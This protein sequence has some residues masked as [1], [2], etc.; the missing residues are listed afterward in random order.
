MR[1]IDNKK[2]E[3]FLLVINNS[4]A[5][6]IV[7]CLFAAILT[8]I[9]VIYNQSFVDNG[10]AAIYE[11]TDITEIQPIL[12]NGHS[13]L[14]LIL[15]IAL[16]VFYYHAFFQTEYN[17]TAFKPFAIVISL[18]FSCCMMIGA[19]FRQYNRIIPFHRI[20]LRTQILACVAFLGFA[21][22]YYAITRFIV[23]VIT[24][25]RCILRDESSTYAQNRRQQVVLKNKTRGNLSN[26]GHSFLRHK[27]I[28]YFM[29]LFLCYLPYLIFFYPGTIQYDAM[30]QINGYFGTWTFTNHH[31]T[32]STI[33]IGLFIQLGRFLYNDNLGVFLY[34][35]V[36]MTGMAYVLADGLVLIEK[37]TS[38]RTPVILSLLYFA[39]SPI[40]P[41]YSITIIKDIS[42]SIALFHFVAIIIKLHLSYE[43]FTE[44]KGNMVSFLLT[45]LFVCLFRHEGIFVV[46]VTTVALTIR[47]IKIKST[48][49]ILSSFAACM[50][51][52]FT[53]NSVS[54]NVFG[55]VK[56]SS[57]SWLSI[58]LQQTAR[59]VSVHSDEVSEAERQAI[60]NVLQYD[61]ITEKYYPEISD[62][63]K[64]L[65]KMN[66]S[67][68]PGKWVAYFKVWF[69]QFLKHPITYMEA[70]INNCY[71][72]FYPDRD[73][74]LDGIGYYEIEQRPAVNVGS[75]QATA[76]SVFANKR[77]A[78]QNIANGFKKAPL[79]GMLYNCGVQCWIFIFAFSLFISSSKRKYLI[80]LL[81]AFVVFLV[82]IASPVNAYLRY[83]LPIIM[84]LPFTISW[85]N[86]T[87]QNGN[88][89]KLC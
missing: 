62:G 52:L 77:E 9:S 43:D 59:Y 47:Y 53:F 49:R 2:L 36:Q 29:I 44:K 71:G 30:A 57:A 12:V 35:L 58:P 42:Y 84:T 5:V 24:N 87:F 64:N 69:G 45:S 80:P 13:F 54:T 81:P 46:L 8:C 61:M 14:F 74:F 76:L 85:T 19:S 31:P 4:K 26:P 7:A 38:K 60:D 55:V 48:K 72:Y 51:L 32:F 10:I 27:I 34:T 86:Y 20:A 65:V 88:L 82:C 83:I 68:D 23:A 15:A 21:I 78:I 56:F 66:I 37:I 39:L 41:I 17:G 25:N 70:T 6:H 28:I 67:S 40:F 89:S 16:V 22:L 79:V 3:A 75:I 11:F 63:A 1:K 73:I 18:F 33:L 50:I